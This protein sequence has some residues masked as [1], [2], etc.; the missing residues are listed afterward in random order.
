MT[1]NGSRYQHRAGLTLHGLLA[2]LEVDPR[3]V[4]VMHG[5][6]IY[7][8]GRIPDAVLAE[9]DILEIVTMAQGG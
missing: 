7:R 5:E 3:L 8:A 9:K 6:A 1:V 4:V 2:E